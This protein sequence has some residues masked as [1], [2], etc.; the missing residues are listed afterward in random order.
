VKNWL[1]DRKQG[2]YTAAAKGLN[3]V[4]QGIQKV[5]SNI[6]KI[7]N[8][9]DSNMIII[10]LGKGGCWQGWQLVGCQG[11]EDTRQGLNLPSPNHHV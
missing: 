7:F 6:L 5:A 4:Q 2:V 11:Q 9:T 3:A 1:N 8:H 10:T